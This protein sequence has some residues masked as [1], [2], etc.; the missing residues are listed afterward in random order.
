MVKQ[1]RK[2]YLQSDSKLSTSEGAELIGTSKRTLEFY[3][4]SVKLAEKHQY[5]FE[6]SM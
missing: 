5:P 2:L 3:L 1:W 6:S 4:Q